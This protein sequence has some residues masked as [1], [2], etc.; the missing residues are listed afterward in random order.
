MLRTRDIGRIDGRKDER[1]DHYRAPAGRVPNYFVYTRLGLNTVS[2]RQ[3]SS[4]L[5]RQLDPKKKFYQT[6]SSV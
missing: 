6:L 2:C 3:D 4:D 5:S 1:T